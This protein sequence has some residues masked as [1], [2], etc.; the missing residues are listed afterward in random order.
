M[1]TYKTH[2]MRVA[3]LSFIWDKMRTAARETALRNCSQEAG[4]KVSVYEILVTEEY[5]KPA[6]LFFQKVSTS[7]MKLLLVTRNSHQHGGF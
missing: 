2:N 7:I 5:M 6:T 4:R 1:S 3:S